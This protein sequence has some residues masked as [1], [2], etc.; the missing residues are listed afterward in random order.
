MILKDTLPPNNFIVESKVTSQFNVKKVE[1]LL[2]EIKI[3]P[4]VIKSV[5]D[6]KEDKYSVV[7]IESDK[8]IVI[9]AVEGQKTNVQVRYALGESLLQMDIF[10]V[11]LKL[12]DINT[13]DIKVE[14][15]CVAATQ[16]TLTFQ[17]MSVGSYLLS[18]TLA[19]KQTN[20][21]QEIDLYLTSTVEVRYE[22]FYVFM[23]RKHMNIWKYVFLLITDS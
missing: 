13:N 11:C 3:V 6:E 10:D 17:E 20:T 4:G 22:Y 5:I 16:R 1:E 7:N 18:L 12:V 15:A 19:Q 9:S 21:N 14:L 2:P 8:E 23:I